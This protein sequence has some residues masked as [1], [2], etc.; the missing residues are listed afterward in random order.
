MH[1]SSVVDRIAGETVAVW[2]I[3]SR[4]A[5]AKSRG[6]DVIIL[7]I[8]DP[9]VDTPKMIRDA[10]VAGLDAGDTHYVALEGKRNL[11]DAVAARF[12][13]RVGQPLT[14]D[15]VAITAGAQN[16][17][18]AA[19]MCI[20]ED[21]DE[22]AA[23]DPM[24]VSYEAT[25]GVTG[26][27]MVRVLTR[28]ENGFHPTLADFEAALSERTRAIMLATP[29]NPTGA[30]L[31]AG[32]LEMIAG[33][34]RER[35]LWVLSD[36]V[37]GETAFEAPH[38]SIAALPGMAERTVTIGSLSKS[39]A[40]TGWRV[41]WMI[42]PREMIGHVANLALCTVFGLPGFIQ[43]GGVAALATADGWQASAELAASV[44]KRRDQ[45]VDGL[46]A[47]PPLKPLT[48]EGGMFVCVDV[49][50]TG[51]TAPEFSEALFEAEKVSVLDATAFGPSTDGFVRMFYG[52]K[53]EV[54][55]EALTR[56][57]RFVSRL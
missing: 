15:D 25:V 57:G 3:H 54:L 28:P 5:A 48:P 31:T 23:V 24:Y 8:G 49:R 21:D 45:L 18:F 53:P 26:A 40:M 19:A 41:G 42:A 50:E 34:A 35:D 2:D 55:D 37:Y 9:D 16:A 7:S 39:H 43:E 32:E 47:I 46:K 36:E 52:L 11:R 56:I 51:L 4:A 14:G 1:Y 30:V 44:L 10:T 29:N 33:I 38:L 22:I 13:D 20:A 17:L 6:E 12:A 27:N